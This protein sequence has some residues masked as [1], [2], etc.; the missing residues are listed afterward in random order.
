MISPD[1]FSC[2]LVSAAGRSNQCRAWSDGL[3]SVRRLL[4]PWVVGYAWARATAG[5]QLVMDP[6]GVRSV[7]RQAKPN[8]GF[9]KVRQRPRLRF[10]CRSAQACGL[11]S[12]SGFSPDA[13][14]RA[15]ILYGLYKTRDSPEKGL[16]ALAL[17]GVR[18]EGVS[19][20]AQGLLGPRLCR[21]SLHQPNLRQTWRKD[22]IRHSAALGLIAR[23]SSRPMP[24]SWLP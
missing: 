23:E 12:A 19:A 10:A 3:Q 17:P 20:H 24:A 5:L 11:V 8:G 9:P 13:V 1:L 6:R 22:Q 21:R 18:R 7:S 2:G 14:A 16:R 15:T 4:G